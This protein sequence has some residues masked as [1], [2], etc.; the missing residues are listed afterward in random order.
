MNFPNLFLVLFIETKFGVLQSI[1]YIYFM[2]CNK[3]KIDKDISNFR[4]SKQTNSGYQ[5]YCIECDKAFQKVYYNANKEKVIKNSAKQRDISRVKMREFLISYLES[6]PCV[7]CGES[8]IVVLEFDHLSNKINNVSTFMKNAAIKKLKAE[9]PK[10]QVLCAN[11]HRRKTAKDQNW[12][13][14]KAS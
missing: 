7:H 13:K 1:L 8:D 6:H 3:C 4:K 11:C 2:I 10:C 5:Y 12:Y 14:Q 9:I